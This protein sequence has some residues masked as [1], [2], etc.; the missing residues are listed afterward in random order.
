[1]SEVKSTRTVRRGRIFP[2]IQWT[3]EQLAQWEAERT[4][5][6]QRCQIIFDRVKSEYLQTHYNWYIAIEPDSGEYFI[7]KDE[8]LVAQIAHQKYPQAKLYVFRIN[9]TGVCGTI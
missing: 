3:E 9:E 8:F 4:A 5:F 2:Q 7:D 1:M 6:R